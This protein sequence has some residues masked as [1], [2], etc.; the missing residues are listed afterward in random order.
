MECFQL[1]FILL[2]YYPFIIREKKVE[3]QQTD[4]SKSSYKASNLL[5]LVLP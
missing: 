5:N 4:L 1:L 2:V 3:S